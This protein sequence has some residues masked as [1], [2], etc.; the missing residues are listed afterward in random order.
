MTDWLIFGNVVDDSE[1][2]LTNESIQFIREQNMIFR[3]NIYCP[4]G[5]GGRGGTG[6][7]IF[8]LLKGGTYPP[9]SLSLSAHMVGILCK[10]SNWVSSHVDKRFLQGRITQFDVKRGT[11]S[12]RNQFADTV[13]YLRGW[14]RLTGKLV[15]R[16]NRG[17]RTFV[18]SKCTVAKRQRGED[19]LYSLEQW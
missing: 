16:N 8:I 7:F 15:A 14:E 9:G 6:L 18:V 10:Y 5:G 12:E 13:G 19:F 11:R 17:L 4:L 1:Q 2:E 3:S